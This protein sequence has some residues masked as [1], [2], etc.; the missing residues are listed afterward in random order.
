MLSPTP[1]LIWVHMITD[2]VVYGPSFTKYIL[3]DVAIC[4]DLL[5]M[6]FICS[7]QWVLLRD[8]SCIGVCV[9]EG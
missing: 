5:A 4:P 9:G 7:C 8:A 2:E 3:Y 6:R 1:M